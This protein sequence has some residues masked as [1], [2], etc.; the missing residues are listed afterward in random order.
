MNTLGF[1]FLHYSVMV[2]S[3][4]V[5]LDA[6]KR[7]SCI[8]HCVIGTRTTLLLLLLK[9]FKYE[10]QCITHRTIHH[11]HISNGTLFW[12]QLLVIFHIL[13]CVIHI[14]INV[15]WFV[16]MWI[17]SFSNSLTKHT[18]SAKMKR[19]KKKMNNKKTQ[20]NNKYVCVYR[21]N[22]RQFQLQFT[23]IHIIVTHD[24]I[25][26]RHLFV[27]V[28]SAMYAARHNLTNRIRHNEV[29]IKCIFIRINQSFCIKICSFGVET[30]TP[31]NS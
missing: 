25:S 21:N 27:R 30:V 31:P 11:S 24:F 23:N 12:K 1:F 5:V 7:I 16:H 22:I 14:H 26:K 2:D 8:T 20:S 18:L 10:R 19:R 4:G 28:C 15:Q 9:F 3:F 6:F 29:Y 17:V 13:F